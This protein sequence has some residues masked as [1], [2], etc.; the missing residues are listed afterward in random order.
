MSPLRLG[1][2]G[3]LVLASAAYLTLGTGPFLRWL[4][5]AAL[6]VGLVELRPLPRLA[7]RLPAGPARA[8]LAR[9]APYLALGVLVLVLLGE[10]LLGRPP[11]SRDHAIHYFQ[12]ELLVHDLLPGG[13]L[14]G[15]SD[16]LG[17]GYTLGDSYPVLGYL[18]MGAAH[19]LSLGLIPLRASYAL[20]IFAMWLLAAGGVFRLA[21]VVAAEVLPRAGLS[22]DR[23]KSP[24]LA[25]PAWAGCLGA[26]LWLLDTGASREGGWEYLMFHGVW[27]QLLA[28]ALWICALPATYSALREP[29]P[30][31]LALAGG[32]LGLSVLAHPFAMLMVGSSAAAWAVLLTLRPRTEDLRA[33]R[34]NFTRVAADSGSKLPPAS[35]TPDS[36]PPDANLVSATAAPLPAEPSPVHALDGPGRWR[37]FLLLHALAAALC[38]GW[39]SGFLASADSMGRS[40]VPWQSWGE[41]ATQLVGGELFDAH[42]AWVG[43]LALLGLGLALRRGA[44][45]A[46]L[47]AGLLLATLVLASDAAITVLR[48]D[49]L[50]SA[51]KNIQFPRY[52]I[53]LKPLWY[54]LAGVGAMILIVWWRQSATS[55]FSLTTGQHSSPPPAT[56]ANSTST[57]GRK[58]ISRPLAWTAC[59]L[60]APILAGIVE[61]L[62]RLA[63]VPIGARST[64]ESSATHGPVAADLEEALTAE[65][66][67][68]PENFRVA[69]LRG[70]MGGGTYPI[71][72]IADLHAGLVLDGH[73]PSINSLYRIRDRNPA[74]LR[75]L[76]VTHVVHDKPISRK[77]KPLADAL[78]PIVKVGHYT[79]ARLPARPTP[80]TIP[81][82]ATWTADLQVTPTRREPHAVDLDVDAAG[83]LNLLRSPDRHWRAT[84][85]PADGSDPEP[86]E[87]T[88]TNLLGN[89]VTG[90]RVELPG[91]GRLELR[92]T[93]PPR[94]RALGWVS[95]AAALVALGALLL[96]RP[97][98][99]AERLQTP[100]AR[101]ISVT[102]TALL[103]AAVLALAV[104]RQAQQ[105]GRTWEPLAPGATLVA[106]LVDTGAYAVTMTPA[107]PCDGLG[108]KDARHGCSAARDRPRR[109][110]LYRDPYLYRCLWVTVPPRGST[111]VRFTVPDGARLTGLIQRQTP[112]GKAN[113]KLH[114]TVAGKKKSNLKDRL[115]R[116]DS[117]IVE[118]ANGAGEFERV[119]LTAAAVR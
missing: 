106:D 60:L 85:I 2:T 77:E 74:V 32:L 104:R 116:F 47:T 3:A 97:L 33:A 61:D 82:L 35:L 114:L 110:L 118:L 109:A 20:G 93:T 59:I 45:L 25:A 31:R 86:L 70:G 40:P 49:L 107:D 14:R 117:P 7:A 67:A 1:L 79:L 94:E 58:Y 26:A 64:L 115:E 111:T 105:L 48:L 72:A 98:E 55:T 29:S 21:T 75:A 37:S 108:G 103:C 34:P 22:T 18:W 113:K 16:R 71:F 44:L 57:I 17:N 62:S 11:A 92:Y 36:G 19:L 53:A 100:A 54:A 78:E 96:R 65:Q 101:R 41:V 28:T 9:L 56:P 38:A 4:A 102:L 95:L 91:P 24:S 23:Q 69:F 84:F 6:L 68:D 30:R 90:T 46:W 87:M 50:V 13:H 8:R 5:A 42:R 81:G 63:P 51:F 43:P 73:I 76:G 112:G 27:P 66:A 99:F 80:R 39:V 88:P 52:A 89:A 15:W 12:T 119:C 83:G 10:L